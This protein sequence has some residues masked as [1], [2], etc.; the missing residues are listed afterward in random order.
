M[1]NCLIYKLCIEIS[2]TRLQAFLEVNAV[3]T[4]KVI[5]IN[6]AIFP[7]VF[8][9]RIG[10]PTPK[11]I[12]IENIENKPEMKAPEISIDL[13]GGAS[14]LYLQQLKSSNNELE[15]RLLEQ[16]AYGVSFSDVDYKDLLSLI[17]VPVVRNWGGSYSLTDMLAS[18]GVCISTGENGKHKFELIHSAIPEIKVSTWE[19]IIG[20]CQVSCRINFYSTYFKARG[21]NVISRFDIDME[22]LPIWL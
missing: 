7:K 18:F 10:A 11:N 3:E 4:K 15:I 1:D 21:Y 14:L 22:P 12:E 2:I 16:Y 19:C 6:T 5:E 20:A 8:T 17:M 13:P 9:V